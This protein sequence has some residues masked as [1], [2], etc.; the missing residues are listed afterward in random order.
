ME[1]KCY[2]CGSLL[3]L[4]RSRNLFICVTCETDVALV[5]FGIVKD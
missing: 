3:R 2:R 4:R 5:A 1:E